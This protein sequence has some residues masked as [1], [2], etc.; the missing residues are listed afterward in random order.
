MN[1]DELLQLYGM[2]PDKEQRESIRRLLQQEMENQKI[3]D[4]EVLKLLCIMLFAIGNVEDTELIWQAKRKNQDAGSYI[5]VQLL[6]G[7]GVEET[8]VYLE[9]KGRRTSA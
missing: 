7:A 4:H 2:E 3:E 6:C 5:D 8:I 9:K 1:E